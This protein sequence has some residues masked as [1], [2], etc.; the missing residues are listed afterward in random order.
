MLN[1]LFRGVFQKMKETLRQK[2][3][4]LVKATKGQNAGLLHPTLP[5][6][7]PSVVLK[8]VLAEVRA[9]ACHVQDERP[10]IRGYVKSMTDEH[11]L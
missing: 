5:K 11:L 10:V 9:P 3:L 7:F 4:P 2:Y 1:T 6:N 8:D